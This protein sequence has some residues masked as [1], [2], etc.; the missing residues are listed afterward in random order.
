L[1]RSVDALAARASRRIGLAVA[2]LSLG[3]AAL[4]IARQLSAVVDRWAGDQALFFG[5]A[6]VVLLSLTALARVM[7][8]SQAL[9]AVSTCLGSQRP[10]G[11]DA[12]RRVLRITTMPSRTR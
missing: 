5:A 1:V 8:S 9:P 10:W 12:M 6:T 2:A 3:V 11:L 7:P 4:G